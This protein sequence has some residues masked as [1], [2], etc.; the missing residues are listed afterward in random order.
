MA[1][2]ASIGEVAER[3]PRDSG[4]NAS[5]YAASS[6]QRSALVPDTHEVTFRH[7]TLR[8]IVGVE[9]NEQLPGPTTMPLDVGVTGIQIV[10]RFASDELQALPGW[11]V[12]GPG[13]RI[14]AIGAQCF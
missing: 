6:V 5:R 7:S 9:L 2:A 10:E 11:N 4:T 13:Q 3:H 12:T 14:V 8:R 1:V